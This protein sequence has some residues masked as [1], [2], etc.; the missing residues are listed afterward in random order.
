MRLILVSSLILSACVASPID[1]DL[2]ELTGPDTSDGEKADLADIPLTVVQDNIG[3][4]AATPTQRL[5]TNAG[6]YALF[7]GHAPP[8]QIRYAEDRL[9]EQ[10]GG[11][12]SRAPIQ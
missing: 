8:G 3:N 10:A 11:R 5:F 2:P 9:V 7:F 1:G 4:V 12:R 6:S